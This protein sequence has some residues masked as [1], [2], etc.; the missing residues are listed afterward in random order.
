MPFHDNTPPSVAFGGS[1]LNG[2]TPHSTE[3]ELVKSES[4]FVSVH[5]K[6][7]TSYR[8]IVRYKKPR[9]PELPVLRKPSFALSRGRALTVAAVVIEYRTMIE[10]INFN[11]CFL[12]SF[13][14]V[15]RI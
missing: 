10:R 12:I 5:R 15:N 3:F 1:L 7:P 9:L 2:L 4:R 8:I 13:Y 6:I 11:S 14:A